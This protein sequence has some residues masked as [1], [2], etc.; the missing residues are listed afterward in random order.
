MRPIVNVPEEDRRTKNLV[1]IA[2]VVP[3]IFSRTDRHT[4]TQTDIVI[5]ILRNEIKTLKTPLF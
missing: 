5:T 4:D 3:E 1:K 2:C